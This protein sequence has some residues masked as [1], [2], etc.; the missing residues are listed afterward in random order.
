MQRGE[1][2][3]PVAAALAR[4]LSEH[5]PRFLHVDVR[6]AGRRD[7][8][9][10]APA[11]A[12]RLLD[13]RPARAPCRPARAASV[14]RA[15]ADR[16]ERGHRGPRRARGPPPLDDS[17][18]DWIERRTI[19][20]VVER[21]ER[22]P[23]FESAAAGTP[24]VS[25]SRPDE[26][27]PAPCSPSSC[28]APARASSTP[29]WDRLHELAARCSLMAGE[30]DGATSRRAAGWRA[31]PGRA[32]QS[33]WTPATR[34]QLEQPRPRELVVEFLDEHLGDRGVVDREP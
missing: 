14:W 15:R 20:E 24:R 12:G 22:Q 28:E 4:T 21:W 1:A 23:V 3:Q 5:L 13:G 6:G 31:D 29:V 8:G 27:R 18:A 25:A 7:P 32:G 26:P 19:E 10:D 30:Q 9:R 34:P 33:A 16:G 2:W 11:R 17:L